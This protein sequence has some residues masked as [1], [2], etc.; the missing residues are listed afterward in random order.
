[1]Y[2][3]GRSISEEGIDILVRMLDYNPA[4]RLTA[5]E[6]LRHPYFVSEMPR[7]C[8]ESLMPTFGH[9]SKG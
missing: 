7:P 1:M 2:G 8:A 3:A 9:R 6:A 5:K 4:T